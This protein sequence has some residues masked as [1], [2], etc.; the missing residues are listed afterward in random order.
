MFLFSWEP[1]LH[2]F[3]IPQAFISYTYD[4]HASESSQ[5]I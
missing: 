1:N 2:F 5:D 4:A 3:L